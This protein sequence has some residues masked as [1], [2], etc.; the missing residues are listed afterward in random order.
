MGAP[1]GSKRRMTSMSARTIAGALAA[2]LACRPD[3]NRTPTADTGTDPSTDA[4]ATGGT[5]DPTSS[6][7]AHT[8]PTS[9]GSSS[10]GTTE[11][12]VSC[13]ILDPHCPEGQICE[14]GFENASCVPDLCIGI[15]CD[16]GYD[17]YQGVCTCAW[18]DCPDG[19]YCNID[20]DP[21]TCEPD[22]CADDECPIFSWCYPSI[23]SCQ[24]CPE[25]CGAGEVCDQPSQTCLPITATATDA[26]ADAPLVIV[27]PY[28]GEVWI[29]GDFGAATPEPLVADCSYPDTVD[30]IVRIQLNDDGTFWFAGLT[31]S[32]GISARL[33]PGYC[34]TH[35]NCGTGGGPSDPLES[36]DFDLGYFFDPGTYV[37]VVSG[38]P[39][40]GQWWMRIFQN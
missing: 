25:S 32:A 20:N 21:A 37:L 3:D 16:E 27:P 31:E 30:Q 18:S 40:A 22:P 14:G 6:T 5:S 33:I 19:T 39:G 23:G 4:A 26:C 29:T 17:C 15:R 10:S 28:P 13:D 2:L 8:E 12:L 7:A 1:A 24:T 34:E 38:P 9:G 11:P 35:E 36:W